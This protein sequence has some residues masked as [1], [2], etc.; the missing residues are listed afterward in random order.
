[1]SVDRDREAV[2][3]TEVG[4]NYVVLVFS[5]CSR[6]GD[7]GKRSVEGER[8]RKVSSGFVVWECTEDKGISG[9]GNGNRADEADE[10]DMGDAI[11]SVIPMS[12]FCFNELFRNLSFKITLHILFL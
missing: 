7:R 12:C 9:S 1:M 10:V 11:E 8:M 6:T 5:T 3:G 4:P 2:G